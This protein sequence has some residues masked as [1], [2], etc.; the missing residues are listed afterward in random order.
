MHG[1]A[2]GGLIQRTAPSSSGRLVHRGPAGSLSA[3]PLRTASGIAPGADPAALDAATRL[4]MRILPHDGRA[5]CQRLADLDPAG[6]AWIHCRVQAH[7]YDLQPTAAARTKLVKKSEDKAV[8]RRGT[9]G[10]SQSWTS[11]LQSSKV[12]SEAD[13]VSKEHG[14]YPEWRKGGLLIRPSAT[15]LVFLLFIFCCHLLIDLT[16]TAFGMI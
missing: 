10:F 8:N 3:S 5:R 7:H 13:I 16:E 15:D 14:W 1:A 2:A 11:T 4:Q 12:T 9:T 6:T